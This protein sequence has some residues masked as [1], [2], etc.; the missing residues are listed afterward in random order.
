MSFIEAGTKVI[1]DIFTARN[2]LQG[3]VLENILLID[4]TEQNRGADQ[5]RSDQ[6]RVEQFQR[7]SRS[8]E[9][10]VGTFS[11]SRRHDKSKM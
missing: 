2:L 6:I 11:D 7:N 3:A 5:I 1:D 9:K 8:P 10:Q 4:C